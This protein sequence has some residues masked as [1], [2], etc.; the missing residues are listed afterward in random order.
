MRLQGK[1][2][3]IDG[4]ANGSAGMAGGSGG[5][6]ILMGQ[7]VRPVVSGVAAPVLPSYSQA[8]GQTTAGATVVR[9]IRPAVHPSTTGVVKRTTETVAV[10]GSGSTQRFSLTVP[11]LSALLAG[12][13]TFSLDSQEMRFDENFV[14]YQERLR[15][16]VRVLIM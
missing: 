14:Y 6:T 12:I 10:N 11:A 16:I 5:N 15:L 7:V 2:V 4:G 3:A 1:F 9:T 13:A 8:I